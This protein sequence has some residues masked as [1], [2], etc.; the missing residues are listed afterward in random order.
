VNVCFT[1]LR[2][3]NDL[4]FLFYGASVLPTLVLDFD[5]TVCV[6]EAPVR[7]Y[8]DAVLRHLAE[9][10][11]GVVSAAIDAYLHGGPGDHA[12]GYVAVAELA[13]PHVAPAVLGEAYAESR[14]A[15]AAG[16]LDIATPAGLPAF[17]ASL[18]G[19]A[20]R[21]LVTNAPDVGVTESLHVLGLTA[22]IDAVHTGAAKPAGFPPLLA[23]LLAGAPAGALLS[24]GDVWVNDI[25]PPLE[26]GCA[27]A[28]LARS[29]HDT[30]PAHL[31]ALALPDLYTA[32]DA[33]V[34]DPASLTPPDA[35]FAAPMRNL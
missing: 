17:L 3:M 8:A 12:D 23:E 21:V 16:T 1:D 4:F 30:R 34:T 28:Y 2:M 9:G 19:R 24:V 32:I 7:C 13:G 29:A 18:E 26:A 11:A 25:E 5:G 31:R 20:R 35:R 33:W 27:T 15:L 10:P 6:G 14:R 22:V